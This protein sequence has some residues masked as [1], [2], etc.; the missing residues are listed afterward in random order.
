M[1]E[2]QVETPSVQN[3]KTCNLYIQSLIT[4]SLSTDK[5]IIRHYGHSLLGSIRV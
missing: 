4:W 5:E 2:K 1:I 3:N